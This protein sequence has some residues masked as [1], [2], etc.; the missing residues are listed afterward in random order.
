M[1]RGAQDTIRS[2]LRAVAEVIEKGVG[3][4][5]DGVCLAVAMPQSTTPWLDMG[6]EE[7]GELC[8]EFGFE[9]VDAEAVGKN[10]FGGEW[11]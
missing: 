10:E 6:G 9:Y 2:L 1:A 8:T 11:A 7:W 3:Y 5:W 4:A